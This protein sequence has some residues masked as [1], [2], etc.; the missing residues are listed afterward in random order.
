MIKQYFYIAHWYFRKYQYIKSYTKVLTMHGKMINSVRQ[1]VNTSRSWSMSQ[2]YWHTWT[3]V[4]MII[5]SSPILCIYFIDDLHFKL[6]PVMTPRLHMMSAEQLNCHIYYSCISD[7]HFRWFHQCRK[8]RSGIPHARRVTCRLGDVTF[9]FT[10][11]YNCYV[12][13]HSYATMKNSYVCGRRL[14][15]GKRL[16]LYNMQEKTSIM[17]LSSG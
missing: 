7:R 3:W 10:T 1:P 2:R 11:S 6:Q 15:S 16:Y 5:S 8:N 9:R 17:C 14:F 13:H 12:I 4:S